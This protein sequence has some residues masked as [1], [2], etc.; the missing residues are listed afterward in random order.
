[1][2]DVKKPRCRGAAAGYA[3]FQRNAMMRSMKLHDWLAVERGRAAWLARE[4]E[5]HPV[6]VRQW[7][8]GRAVPLQHCAAIEI[9][10]GGAVTRRE[11]RPDDWRRVWPELAGYVKRPARK[12]AAA[13]R[14]LVA[15]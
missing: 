1:M 7:G 14:L 3:D 8:A 15:S 4:I 11:M 6:L 12:K 5:V 9:A 13:P 10:T 2:D